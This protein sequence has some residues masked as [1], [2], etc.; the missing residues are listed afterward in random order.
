MASVP[1]PDTPYRIQSAETGHYLEL[2]DVDMKT[3]SLQDLK[4]DK[5]LEQQ[6]R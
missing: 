2:R 1:L 3:V 4:D 5:I 6:V